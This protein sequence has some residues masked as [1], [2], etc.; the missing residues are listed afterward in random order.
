MS[1]ATIIIVVEIITAA[2]ITVVGLLVRRDVIGLKPEIVDVRKK[3]D[4]AN[5]VISQQNASILSL[6]DELAHS[7]PIV[8][9]EKFDSDYSASPPYTK[10]LPK[11]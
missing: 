1:D 8:S 3:L 10:P 2:I 7:R 6:R 4:E 5:K 9:K 11:G